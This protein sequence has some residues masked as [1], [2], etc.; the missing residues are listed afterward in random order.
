VSAKQGT[1]KL[2][3]RWQQAPEGSAITLP[4]ERQIRCEKFMRRPTLEF[5]VSTVLALGATAVET[6]PSFAVENQLQA[7]VSIGKDTTY[8]SA[9]INKDGYPDYLAAMNAQLNEGVTPENNAAV[10]LQKALGP[11]LIPE[12]D[13]IEVYKQ[14]GIEPLAPEGSYFTSRKQWIELRQQQLP[15]RRR[16]SQDFEARF[17]EAKDRP[18]S[19]KEFSIVAEWLTHNE[20]PLKIILQASTRSKYFFPLCESDNQPRM[21]SADEASLKQFSHGKGVPDYARDAQYTNGPHGF[22]ITRFASG[23]SPCATSAANFSDRNSDELQFG[24][25]RMSR[26]C[27]R[28]A[29][30]SHDY[31]AG[32]PI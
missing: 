30:R 25:L 9:P 23:S 28:G 5:I 2:P 7:K 17:D 18:W 26:R 24:T 32:A 19:A 13:R 8:I 21:L 4:V 31:V 20:S 1:Q 11:T 10:L 22:C 6:V 3:T 14:L 16:W 29:L 12:K 27:T 15:E